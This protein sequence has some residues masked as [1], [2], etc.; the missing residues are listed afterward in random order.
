MR[1]K[2]REVNEVWSSVGLLVMKKM[3]PATLEF[4]NLTLWCFVS[5][6]ESCQTH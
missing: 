1:V 3:L 4:L 5:T 6:D 2:I